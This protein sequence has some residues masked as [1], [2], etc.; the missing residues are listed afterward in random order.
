MQTDKG[1]P[2]RHETPGGGTFLK[3]PS[4]Q[5]FPGG[6]LNSPDEDAE[7]RGKN[8]AL[9]TEKGHWVREPMPLVL[10]EQNTRLNTV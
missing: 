8:W 9:K 2:P 7:S 10:D 3:T 1:I 5:G 4:I 6:L